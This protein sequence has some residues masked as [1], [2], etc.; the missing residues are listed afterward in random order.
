MKTVP[1]K[2]IL[3]T[4]RVI[5]FTAM[6]LIMTGT[7]FVYGSLE[8]TSFQEVEASAMEVR[9][10][11]PLDIGQPV[12]L[13]ID[14]INMALSIREGGIN[15]STNQW[16]LDDDNVFYIRNSATPI[17][18]GHNKKGVFDQLSKLEGGEPLLVTTSDGRVLEFIFS[19]SRQIEPS[20][21]SILSERNDK[22]IILLTCSGA[23]YEFRQAL[24]FRYIGEQ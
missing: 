10:E 15:Q 8:N 17:L 3:S 6:S 5:S 18:Y 12:T 20:D 2:K 13:L 1:V 11:E 14:K 21:K 19:A 7:F 4:E 24:Y 9:P 16:I 22:T 23:F